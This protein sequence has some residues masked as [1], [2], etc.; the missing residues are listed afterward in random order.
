MADNCLLLLVLVVRPR[1]LEAV[2][3]VLMSVCP[4]RSG[5]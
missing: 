3:V 5:G 1:R 2:V 4:W